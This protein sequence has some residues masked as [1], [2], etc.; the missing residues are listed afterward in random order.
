[1]HE[2]ITIPAHGQEIITC[3]HLLPN[4]IISASTDCTICV[5]DRETGTLLCQLRGHR[6]AI[7]RLLVDE[8]QQLL[9]SASTDFTVR[10]WSLKEQKSLYV[11][12]G[13]TSTV[14][15]LYLNAQYLVS[16]GRDNLLKVWTLATSSCP[17]LCATLTG[18]TNTI[19]AIDGR[20]DTV[21]SGSYDC[22]VKVWNIR[23]GT[24]VHTLQGHTSKIMSVAI[25]KETAEGSSAGSWC[26]SGSMDNTIR[27]WSIVSGEC[28]HVY[29]GHTGLVSLLS[30]EDRYAI[31]ASTD[32]T[33]RVWDPEST[34]SAD[35]GSM[36]FPDSIS[37]LQTKRNTVVASSRTLIQLYDFQRRQLAASE[38]IECE[39]IWKLSLDD[40]DTRK[41]GVLAVGM[42]RNGD[43]MIAVLDLDL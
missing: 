6:G 21:I 23:S 14:R 41:H 28:L 36:T 33:V 12:E 3:L 1:M 4:I 38:S 19:R 34:G 39:S 26:M 27:V 25:G 8:Q 20:G 10:V 43:T 40:D 2:L 24:L 35:I 37:C 29:H 16:G 13:H 18:H 11:L 15:C 30:T 32:G 42:L 31:S 7:W 22:S 5:F 9:Y 17:T